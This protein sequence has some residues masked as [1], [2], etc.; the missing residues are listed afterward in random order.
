VLLAS[1]DRA[2]A[3]TQD[4]AP[5][6]PATPAGR[7]AGDV[8]IDD[9]DVY[10]ESVTSLRDGTL[11]T[12]SIKGVLYRA[13]PQSS[14]AAPW[15]R[16]DETNR[17]QSVFGVLADENTGTLWLCSVPFPNAFNP[18]AEG[19]VAELVALDLA[20]GA[21]KA[22]YAFPPPR[23]V[24][25][26]VTIGPD[27]A[28]YAADTQN[29]RIL[30]LP[31]GGTQL[32]LFGEAEELKGVDG[33]AF[34][35]DGTLYTNI[36][37]R[38]V[39]QRIDIGGDGRMAKVNEIPVGEKLAGPDGMRLI[40]GHRFL[41]AEGNSGRVSVVTFDGDRA[42]LRALDSNLASSPGVTLVGDT[43][44]A[45]EGKIGYL[46]DPKLRGQDPGQFRIVAIPLDSTKV[47]P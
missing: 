2:P 20:S 46:V 5:P 4:P 10:P 12:G 43:V 7:V 16:P 37:T 21:F 28:A 40:D 11:I 17:L 19:A 35:S 6:P 39:L 33:I 1:C 22:R 44:Y 41:M 47:N 8:V 38:G 24:C 18:P 30:K 14:T 31:A 36:V 29:G 25:N 42:T 15:V 32:E 23:S 9:R 26:D 3:P 34:S 45:L 13:E 27:G